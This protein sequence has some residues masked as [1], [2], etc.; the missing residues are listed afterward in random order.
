MHKVTTIT[1]SLLLFSS[2]IMSITATM[3]FKLISNSMA[4]EESSPYLER[5][6]QQIYSNNNDEIYKEDNS[7]HNYYSSQ[8]QNEQPERY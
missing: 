8:S 1:L 7:I 4:I 5:Y 6:T 2:L 3:N